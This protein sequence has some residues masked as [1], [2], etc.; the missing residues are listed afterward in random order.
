MEYKILNAYKDKDSDTYDILIGISGAIIL[1]IGIFL[2][3]TPCAIGGA[4]LT[5][6]PI[7]NNIFDYSKA[8]MEARLDYI[9][10]GKFTKLEKAV[11][12]PEKEIVKEEL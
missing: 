7:V 1:G 11:N 3:E 2:K 4:F 12:A 6:I 8:Y 10:N 5:S 9:K